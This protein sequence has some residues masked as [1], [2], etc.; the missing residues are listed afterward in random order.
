M[1]K[2]SP[3]DFILWPQTVKQ[4]PNAIN[5]TYL[6]HNIT[7]TNALIKAYTNFIVSYS[8]Q[9]YVT[10]NKGRVSFYKCICCCYTA[11]DIRINAW[12]GTHKKF[13]MQNK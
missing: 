3:E 1:C 7:P 12:Y 9:F 2:G 10:N 11:N 4:T 6:I 8:E 5:N 13:L